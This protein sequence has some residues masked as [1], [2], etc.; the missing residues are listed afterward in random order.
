MILMVQND[1][2]DACV[3]LLLQKQN[4]LHDNTN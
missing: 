2:L 1:G 3:E 4:L